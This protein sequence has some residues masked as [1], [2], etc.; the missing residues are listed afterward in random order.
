MRI[1]PTTDT[2]L[3]THRQVHTSITDQTNPYIRHMEPS[4]LL[5][6]PTP[7]R[8]LALQQDRVMEELETETFSEPLTPIEDRS[9]DNETPICQV[10][11][12][13]GT[14]HRESLQLWNRN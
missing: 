1:E 3:T 11:P 8:I 4:P 2:D 10:Q 9:L 12:L 5:T 7:Q 6:P 13:S 14:T